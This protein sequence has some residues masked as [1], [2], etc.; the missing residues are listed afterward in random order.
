[1]TF[2]KHGFRAALFLLAA[3]G[4]LNADVKLPAI[5]GD[6]MV[7]QQSMKLPVW[8]K[9]DPGEAITV[10]VGGETGKATADAEGKWRVDLAPLPAGSQPVTVVVSGKTTITLSDV[11]VGDVWLCSGQS[12]MEFGMDMNPETKKEIPASYSPQLRL[13]CVPKVPSLTP[14]DDLQGIK[15]DALQGHWQVCSPQV[16][17]KGGTWSGFSAVSYF[18]GRAVMQK[19]GHPVGLIAS[20]WGGTRAQAWMSLS[21]LQKD[22]ALKHYVDEYNRTVADYPKTKPVYDAQFATYQTDLAAWQANVLPAYQSTLDQWNASVRAAQAEHQ[23]P[24]AKPE[25]SSPMPK[26]PHE[27]NGGGNG[28]TNLFN[29]MIAPLMPFAIKGVIWYQGESNASLPVEYRTLFSRLIQD[30]REKWGQR[31]FPFLFV[32]L[33]GYK[34]TGADW[35]LLRESQRAALSLPNTGMATAVDI[36]NPENI[37]PADKH[38]VGERLALVARRL[39]YGEKVA[40]SGPIFDAMKVTGNSISVSFKDDGG[41][42]IIGQAPWVPVDAQRLPTTN[43]LGF[44]IAGADKKWMPAEARIEDNTVVVSSSQVSTPVAVRYD[45]ANAPQGN[46]YNKDNLPA[47]P[48]R[49]DDWAEPTTPAS[50]ASPDN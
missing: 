37:H 46:L 40:S 31:A 38:D 41:G 26:A 19:T 43:L 21:G 28:P 10:T 15:G 14:L 23:P 42:L 32:E 29:A 48:F 20:D 4:I 24:P 33:A 44:T 8:G 45:W 36:G 27:A 3:S 7:L 11:L 35:S 30:W 39:A 49:T 50:S 12:N 16:L 1:M 5:F 2:Y 13:F 47:S 9:A 22:A 17:T 18:F 6:H 34:A 25:P